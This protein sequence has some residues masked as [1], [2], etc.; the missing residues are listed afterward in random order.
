MCL[1]AGLTITESGLRDKIRRDLTLTAAWLQAQ[2][3]PVKHST[4]TVDGQ[5]HA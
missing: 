1:V 5:S 2:S 3:S 4:A